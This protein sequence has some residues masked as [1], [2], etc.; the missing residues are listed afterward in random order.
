[1]K[2]KRQTVDGLMLRLIA[3]TRGHYV[4]QDTKMESRLQ[5]RAIFSESYLEWHALTLFPGLETIAR[6]SEAFEYSFVFEVILSSIDTIVDID[7]SDNSYNY[8]DYI[9]LTV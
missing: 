2:K 7:Q 5:K 9:S 1:M 8:H 3:S 6:C 4:G